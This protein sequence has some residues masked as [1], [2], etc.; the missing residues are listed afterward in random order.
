MKIFPN[1]KLAQKAYFKNFKEVQDF[2]DFSIKNFEDFWEKQA[3]EN[4][5]F[6]EN[7]T[8]VLD[9]KDY[10]KVSWFKN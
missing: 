2:Y 7:F 8:E 9:E 6:F 4:L 3:H 1:E 10:P 5:T